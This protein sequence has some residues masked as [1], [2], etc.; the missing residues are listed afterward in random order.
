MTLNAGGIGL[1]LAVLGAPSPVLG[2][3]AMMSQCWV[4]ADFGKPDYQIALRPESNLVRQADQVPQR[5]SRAHLASA[6]I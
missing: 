4:S 6:P 3:F 5:A 2:S 1:P